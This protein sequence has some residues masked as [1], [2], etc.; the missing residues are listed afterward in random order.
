MNGVIAKQPSNFF[1]CLSTPVFERKKTASCVANALDTL[2][3]Y[4][5][6][7]QVTEEEYK[8]LRKEIKSAPHDDAIA[9][10]MCKLRKR[11]YG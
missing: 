8:K 2:G 4:K 1:V 3:D 7:R 6:Y 5:Y 11:V 9:D 10:I